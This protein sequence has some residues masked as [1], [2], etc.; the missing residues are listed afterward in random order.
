M[1]TQ[2][3]LNHPPLLPGE[4]LPSLIARLAKLNEYEP[5]SILSSVIREAWKY[6]RKTRLSYLSQAFQFRWL[7]ALTNIEPYGLYRATGH[8]FSSIST[9]PEHKIESIELSDGLSVPLLS[10]SIAH[11]HL[12]PEYAGQFCP[13]CLK[14]AAYHRLI[15][16]PMA[17]AACLDHKCLLVSSCPRCEKPVR[18]Q[19][20]IESHCSNCKADY[21]EV[22]PISIENDSFGLFTQSLIQ[23]WLTEGTNPNSLD[24]PLPQQMPRD[25]YRVI[26]GLRLSIMQVKHDWP[27]LHSLKNY[28]DPLGLRIA[29]MRSAYLQTLTAYQSYCLYATACKGIINWPMGFHLFLTAYRGRE[30]TRQFH[31]DST[32]VEEFGLLYEMWLSKRWKQANLEFVQQAFCEYLADNHLSFPTA[33]FMSK[34][35]NMPELTSRLRYMRMQPAAKLLGTTEA[36]LKLMIQSG[37]LMA[38]NEIGKS[39]VVLVKHEDVLVLRKR[40]EQALDLKKTANWLGLSRKSVPQLVKVGL[41]AAQ[42]TSAE[43]RGW[44]FSPSDVAECLERV[45]E[46]VSILSSVESANR[47]KMLSIRETSNLLQLKL[48][49]GS[50]ALILQKVTD[51]DLHAYILANR[52][53]QL[54]SLIFSRSDIDAYVEAVKAEQDW[55]DRDGVATILGIHRKSVRSWR[56][57]G[58][59]SPVTTGRQTHYYDRQEIEKLKS[60]MVLTAEASEILGVSESA[61]CSL[62]RQGRLIALRGPAVDGYDIYVFSR[63]SLVEW[64]KN[65][66]TLHEAQCQIEVSYTELV[67]WV[68]QGK[69]LPLEDKA[70]KPWYFSRQHISSIVQRTGVRRP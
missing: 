70:L 3:L 7:G 51:G 11:R 43:S 69:L 55:I 42:Q 1:I 46:R 59:I 67:S 9:P 65:R 18:I 40:W 26:D 39:G 31:Y 63:Q 53:L 36:R 35:K 27:L 45:T 23:I 21:M 22:E 41:L 20:I 13:L 37:R 10:G 62:M 14:V 49:S 24:Y 19:D 54:R 64:R 52:R 2:P 16:L 25:L 56:K 57:S 17:S 29:E 8:C 58:L 32:L 34:Y 15:W 66:L 48:G 33:P 44:M 30:K 28:R 47:E 61:V 38:C 12:R 4:S 50:L 68:R 60:D 5:R 6:G